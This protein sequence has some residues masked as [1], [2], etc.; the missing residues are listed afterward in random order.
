VPAQTRGFL[1]SD[2]RGYSAFVERHGDQVARELLARY[3]QVVR[4]VVVARAGAEIRT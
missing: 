1:F 3:R 2:L 4:E